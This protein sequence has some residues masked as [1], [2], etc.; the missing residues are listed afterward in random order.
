[1]D[2]LIINSNNN[3]KLKDIDIFQEIL[4]RFRLKL[5]DDY[6]FIHHINWMSYNL[7]SCII[8]NLLFNIHSS[9]LFPLRF[10]NRIIKNFKNPKEFLVYPA[11]S[12]YDYITKESSKRI[13]KKLSLIVTDQKEF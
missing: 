12:V 11:T 10:F 13:L 5:S 7:F 3:K 9:K 6:G 8:K 2:A 4:H 1:M